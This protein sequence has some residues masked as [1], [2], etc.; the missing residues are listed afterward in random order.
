MTT[1]PILTMNEPDTALT[2]PRASLASL[3]VDARRMYANGA[4]G[5]I[6]HDRLD[7]TVDRHPAWIPPAERIPYEL[8]ARD[9]A[10]I[11]ELVEAGLARHGEDSLY[12][13]FVKVS[14]HFTMAE[15]RGSQF[16]SVSLCNEHGTEGRLLAVLIGADLEMR[17]REDIPTTILRARHET[18]TDFEHDAASSAYMTIANPTPLR[19]GMYGGLSFMGVLTSANLYPLGTDPLTQSDE[20]TDAGEICDQCPDRHPFAPYLPPE[21]ESLTGMRWVIVETIPIRPYLVAP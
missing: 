18:A 7:P 14:K 5:M 12:L 13:H 10:A 4:S 15:G 1:R 21:V 3:S 11:A 16:I 19:A 6:V 17:S 8:N 9:L 20:D 2:W